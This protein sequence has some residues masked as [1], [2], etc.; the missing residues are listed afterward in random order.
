MRRSVPGSIE[1]TIVWVAVIVASAIILEG[2][3][4]FSQMFVILAGG[5]AGSLIVL[6][7]SAARKET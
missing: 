4:C 1:V 5:A 6:G 2:T 3:E 7:G